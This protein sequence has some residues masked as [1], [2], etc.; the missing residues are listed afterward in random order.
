M[1]AKRLF[2][3][4]CVIVGLVLVAAACGDD[5]D[6]TS[7]TDTGEEATRVNMVLNWLPVAE[8]AGW[9]SALEEGYFDEEGLNVVISRGFGSGDTVR[10]V[11]AGEA[12][13]GVA[14]IAA[15][16]PGRVNDDIPV[17]AVAVM[18]ARAPQA[19]FYNLNDGIEEPADLE[20]RTAAC[21]EGNSNLLMWPA[22]ADAAGIDPDAVEFRN[23][24]PGAIIPAFVAGQTDTV[25][26]LV[27][28]EPLIEEQT[29]EDV[30]VF[31]YADEGVDAYGHVIIASDSFLSENPD[32]VQGFVD[33][34]RRGMEF[35]VENPEQA[36]EHLR[37]HAPEND[38][39]QALAAW[40][41]SAE[42]MQ[43]E[44]TEENGIGWMSSERMD[45]T[46]DLFVEVLDLDPEDVN[47]DELYTTEFVE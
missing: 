15:V 11:G 44:D 47:P 4:T 27:A 22:F 9:Y 42:Y 23:T 36:I 13:V 30:G 17:K 35:A 38:E 3:P 12:D 34:V 6:D 1:L 26:E 28:S 19:M 7:A 41:I 16:V 33:A 39:G 24:D 45:Q 20:G 8:A 31:S 14:D 10:R 18:F 43:N 21:S 32:A 29:G 40:D 37:T 5:G 2:K 46:L 25:C